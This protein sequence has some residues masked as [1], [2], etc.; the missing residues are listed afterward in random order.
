M[1]L[2]WYPSNASFPLGLAGST[3]VIQVRLEVET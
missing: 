2:L 1:H 3:D